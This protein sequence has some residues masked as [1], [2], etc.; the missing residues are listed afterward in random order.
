ML[1]SKSIMDESVVRNDRAT[2][3]VSF[4]I[5]RAIL[6]IGILTYHLYLLPVGFGQ[7]I[8]E[9]FFVLSG[10]LISKSLFPFGVASLSLKKSDVML[11]WGRRIKRLGPALWMFILISIILCEVIPNK[12]LSSTALLVG[13][14]GP[15]WISN[16]L[17]VN[18]V[19]ESVSVEPFGGIWSLAIEEQ[20]YLI[21]PLFFTFIVAKFKREKELT[22]ALLC[23]GAVAFLSYLCRVYA[24]LTD[25]PLYIEAYITPYRTFGFALGVGSYLIS[26]QGNKMRKIGNRTSCFLISG[27]VTVMFL[28]CFLTPKYNSMAFLFQ[29]AIIPV[30]MSILCSLLYY[31]H[32]YFSHQKDLNGITK[33]INY[34]GQCSYSTYL[35]HPLV[36]Y[37]FGIHT[38]RG[39]IAVFIGSITLAVFS[40]E[41][42]EKR[43]TQFI[44]RSKSLVVPNPLKALSNKKNPER[45]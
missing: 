4:N 37:L 33:G 43:M 31:H 35:Y 25:L 21:L 38:M 24:H 10:F 20:F 7:A 26:S 29:W 15:I 13:L 23:L 14:T 12:Q 6:S 17:T 1:K 2:A 18:A 45:M 44:F 19:R 16:F 22:I 34:I 40:Y 3:I 39:K 41:L 9:C 5:S 36:I 30:M 8:M 11:F 32:I 27:V 42:F 28:L